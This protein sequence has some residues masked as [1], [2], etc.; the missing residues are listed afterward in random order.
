MQAG[1]RFADSWGRGGRK[2]GRFIF[3]PVW[4]DP[5]T[6]G[7]FDVLIGSH[8]DGGVEV[9]VLYCCVLTERMDS[10]AGCKKMIY[11][12]VRPGAMTN[13]GRERHAPPKSWI[14]RSLSKR[15]PPPC[16][17]WFLCVCVMDLQMLWNGSTRAVE[18]QME[19]HKTRKKT[20]TKN[21]GIVTGKLERRAVVWHGRY[22]WRCIY[23]GK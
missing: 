15:P 11:Q 3:E 18:D 8:A 2:G 1:F 10:R 9:E 17:L 14:F 23:P 7:R 12:P 22:G 16:V 4:F 19:D 5:V 20:T 6:D 21:I 13:S